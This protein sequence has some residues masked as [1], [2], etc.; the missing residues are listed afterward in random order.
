MSSSTTAVPSSSTGIHPLIAWVGAKKRVLGQILDKLPCD[1]DELRNGGVWY[2]EPFLGGGTLGFAI[3]PKRGV[4][5]DFNM[6]LMNMYRTV[7]DDYQRLLSDLED[8]T[9]EFIADKTKEKRMLR[10]YQ[11]RRWYN[12]HKYGPHNTMV[13]GWPPVTQ[14]STRLAAVFMFLANTGYNGLY[15]ENRYG[16]FNVT[17]GILCDFKDLTIR[18][19]L[20]RI[21]ALEEMNTYLVTHVKT[22]ILH[23]MDASEL[24]LK[25]CK[26][27]KRGTSVF[28][29]CDP[30]Y[31]ETYARYLGRNDAPPGFDHLEFSEALTIVT[32]H[33][34]IM[35]CNSKSDASLQTYKNAAGS[36][37]CELLEFRTVAP[38]KNSK[39]SACAVMMLNYLPV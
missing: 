34:D 16:L 12:F 22:V 29:L 7:R 37:I 30:P 14:I 4:F 15:R 25:T 27:K 32:N 10:Y 36:M 13:D 11:H 39:R 28:Y 19:K 9:E 5:S 6:N 24:V 3:L 21:K 8:I 35:V 33:A 38:K 31:C 26:E 1:L 2:I 17:P 20:L 18:R 23:S